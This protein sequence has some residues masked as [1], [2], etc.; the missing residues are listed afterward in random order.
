MLDRINCMI[1]SIILNPLIKQM[2]YLNGD[3]IILSCHSDG[4]QNPS[5]KQFS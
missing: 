1:L 3:D 4:Y 2:L 5:L